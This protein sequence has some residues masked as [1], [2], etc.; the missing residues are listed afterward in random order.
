MATD[1]PG[2]RVT[3]TLFT[4]GRT[5][6]DRALRESDGKHVILKQ[7]E[8]AFPDPGQVSRF[9]FSYDV[10]SKFDHPNIIKALDWVKG[11]KKPVMVLEDNNSIDLVRHLKSFPGQ[12]LPVEQFLNIAV[13]LADALS[14]IHHAHV[15]HKDLHP[16]NILINPETGQVQIIDFGLASLLSREQPSLSA[17]EKLEGVLSYISPEQTGRMN[18]ALDYRTD[19]YTLGVT[20]YYLLTGDVPFHADDALGLVHAH[21]ARIQT[22][23]ASIRDD[24]P[25]VISNIVDKLLNKTA[26]ERYQS[27]LGLCKDLQRCRGALVMNKPLPEFPLALDDIPD[28]FQVP[29]KLYGRKEEVDVLLRR[30]F[31]SASGKPRLLAVSGYS[32]IG[33]S[34]LVHEVHKPI[35]AHNGLFVSGKFDQFQQNIPYS[36]LRQSLKSWLQHVLSL[37]EERLNRLKQLLAD[38]LGA[39]AR[40]LTDFMP[41]F[42][43]LLG[44]LPPVVSLGADEARNRFHAVFHEFIKVISWQRPLVI[45][46]DDVQWADQGTLDLLPVLISHEGCRLLVVMAYRDNEVH[47]MHPL[48]RA[49]HEIEESP[50]MRPTLSYLKLGPLDVEQTNQLLQDALYRPHDD[51]MALAR[52]IHGK[53]AGNPFFTAEFLKKLYTDGLLNFNL[54]QQRWSWNIEEIQSR[55][56]TDNVVELMLGKMQQLPRRTRELIQLAACVGSRFDLDTLAMI[57]GIPLIQLTRAIWPALQDGLLVQ[58]GGD[59]FPGVVEQSGGS[60]TVPRE[61]DN[62]LSQSSPLSPYCRFIHDRML[63]AA[64]E[65]LDENTRKETHLRIG[66]LLLQHAGDSL[67]NEQIFSIVGQLNKGHDLMTDAEERERL[68]RLNLVASGRALEACVWRAASEFSSIGIELLPD[69]AWEVC[70]ELTRD[71]YNVM[72]E[73]E[74]LSGNPELSEQYY[75]LLFDHLQDDLTKAQICATRLVQ[76]IGRGQWFEGAVYA[77]EGLVYLGL[78][79]PVSE[80]EVIGQIRLE[81]DALDK[82]LER[83]SIEGIVNLPEMDDQRLLVAARIFPNLS[84][85]AA[86]IGENTLRDYCAIKGMNLVLE[87]GKSDLAAMQLACYAYYLRMQER[88]T[89]AF[90]IGCQARLIAESYDYCREIANCYNMLAATVFYLKKP[91]D[92]CIYLHERGYQLGLENGEIARAALNICNTL[93]VKVSQGL[94]LSTLRDDAVAIQDVLIR[95]SIF[96]PLA[97]IIEKF[98]R[99]L[100]AERDS[101]SHALDDDFFGDEFEKIRTSFHFTYLNHYRAQLA[102]WCCDYRYALH[103]VRESR[104]QWHRLPPG[105]FT[106]DHLL[107]QGILLAKDWK[108]LDDIDK[109]HLAHCEHTLKVLSELYAVNFMHK[110]H[111]LRAEL[112]RYQGASMEQVAVNYRD[113]IEL[114]GRYGF[115]Q[116]Q[117]L[118]NE[119]FADYWLAHDMDIL[120]ESYLR[121]ALYLYRQWGCSPRIKRISSHYSKILSAGEK[122]IQRTYSRTVTTSSAIDQA[123]DMAS[124]MKSAQLISSELRQDQLAARVLQVIVECAGAT[125]AALVFQEND[126]PV[127]QA[128]IDEAGTIEVPSPMPALNDCKGLPHNIISYV[129]RSDELVNVGDVLGERSFMNDPYIMQYQPRSVLCMPVNYRDHTV[130]ALYLENKYTIDTFNRDRMSVIRLLLSQAAISFENAR[131]FFEVST[132]N[133]TLERKVEQRTHDLAQANESLSQVVRELELANEELNSFSYSVSHDLRSP[134]RALRGFSKIL[135]DD[136]MDQLEDEAANL[137]Q[138][139]IKSSNRMSDLIDGLLELSRMQRRELTRQNVELS[140]MVRDAFDEMK[141]RYPDASVTATCAEHCTVYADERMMYSLV[142]NLIGNAWKYS[143]TSGDAKVEFGVQPHDGSGITEGLGLLPD[144]LPAGEPVYFVRDNG[145]G[146]DMNHADKLFSP[147]QRLHSEKQFTGTGIGLA[148]VKRIIEKHG[149]YIWVVSREG[150]GATFYFT[151]P[152]KADNASR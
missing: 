54:N 80:Q 143:G 64:Y 106:I 14:V 42:E 30:F 23:V 7:L 71:L 67:D 79:V 86:I 93:F 44:A 152:A 70:F 28:R 149:G 114:A 145:V 125:S 62:F 69:N 122:R 63:Q 84:Q 117:A 53:T 115:I 68:I 89:E 76:H 29:Q 51:V 73:S 132:L 6:I 18:R 142:L 98:A 91:L 124:V 17:P 126:T 59:W 38:A 81:Q 11:D 119:L 82:H 137:L 135:K 15:I 83:V 140:A 36:A 78:E 148:T 45:F 128:I 37:S 103:W 55:G 33:K 5:R 9:S 10:L 48:I 110:Y 147:F 121:E 13:Q 113:A 146:F 111:L 107:I 60:Y 61:P 97:G 32:G 100:A 27:A 26:E 102:F 85:C 138:R 1:I 24:V 41:E 127:V 57:A 65:S 49:L 72:A 134:L 123:L 120:A 58:D 108:H 3:E 92:D 39:N 20:F 104:R 87:N 4:S 105:C 35:A 56:I 12:Q 150:E 141:A 95:H 40:I 46:F 52:L 34:A 133:Q 66:R 112:L 130:G 101:P 2:Y 88:Y 94:N 151:L 139:I 96:H 74:Y 25:R 116:Y 8:E 131:L 136:Y 21:I 22:P 109:D 144:T 90:R 99:A 77:R 118:A 50:L 19:F 129:L 47:E 16:G 31:Q 43:H 75:Q